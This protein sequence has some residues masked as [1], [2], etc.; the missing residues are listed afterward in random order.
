MAYVP[1]SL[2]RWGAGPMRR[3][4]A[5]RGQRSG[6]MSALTLAE[7]A[8]IGEMSEAQAM[9]DLQRAL[10]EALAAELGAGL[11]TVGGAVALLMARV[12]QILFNRVIG[13]GVAE[14]AT[15]ALV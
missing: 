1:R 6:T 11:E 2:P 4:T 10:P 5:A 15:E 7:T 14:P 13:L 8:W 9:A 3:S 12:P